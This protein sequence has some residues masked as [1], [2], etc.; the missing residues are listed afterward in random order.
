[1]LGR[2][3]RKSAQINK[4]CELRA[5]GI[6]KTIRTSRLRDHWEKSAFT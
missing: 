4:E 3:G 5:A 2:V 1:M 6:H